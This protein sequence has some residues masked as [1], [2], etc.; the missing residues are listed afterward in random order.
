MQ[1]N[2][3]SEAFTIIGTVNGNGYDFRTNQ[4]HKFEGSTNGLWNKVSFHMEWIQDTMEDMGET[5][6]KYDK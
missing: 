6:C 4:V 2:N 5:V 1:F 3:A